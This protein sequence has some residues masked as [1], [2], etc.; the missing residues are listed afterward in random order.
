MVLDKAD[1]LGDIGIVAY[2]AFFPRIGFPPLL[3]GHA[4]Q[5]D[6]HDI[7]LA[8]IDVV[9]LCRG[10]LGG[11]Q[12]FLN[13]VCVDAIVNLC[14][15]PLDV[16]AELLLLLLLES[17]KLLDQIKLEFHR[18]PCR[19][20]KGDIFVGIG[21]AVAACSG[22]EADGTGCFDPL[23]WSQCKTV[24]ACLFFKPVEFDGF[25]ILIVQIFPDTEKF[26]GIPIPES[27][28]DQIIRPV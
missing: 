9:D 6:I 4:E 27:V 14:Q 28:S 26:D 21:A 19:E 15:I 10:Q 25:K 7:G 18:D 5:S 20:L 23:F 11:N 24:E 22:D 16:P 12:V 1:K 8:G 2:I 13:G 17:L 3:G